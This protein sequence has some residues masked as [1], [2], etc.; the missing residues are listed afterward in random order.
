MHEPQPSSGLDFFQEQQPTHVILGDRDAVTT[1][2]HQ[3]LNLPYG[4]ASDVITSRVS[5]AISLVSDTWVFQTKK[6]GSDEQQAKKWGLRVMSELQISNDDGTVKKELKRQLKAWVV[7]SPQEQL[8][9]RLATAY[10][11][12]PDLFS[13]ATFSPQEAER[14]TA[15]VRTA[16]FMDNFG[17][18]E[19]SQKETLA[20]GVLQQFS[21]YTI[22]YIGKA[23]KEIVSLP[24]LEAAYAMELGLYSDLYD[25]TG[26]ISQLANPLRDLKL[27]IDQ[28]HEREQML[29]LAAALRKELPQKVQNIINPETPESS[30]Q[31]VPITVTLQQW[32]A[33]LKMLE[34]TGV[35]RIAAWASENNRVGR[36]TATEISAVDSADWL[37]TLLRVSATQSHFKGVITNIN[38]SKFANAANGINELISRIENIPVLA[39]VKP[40]VERVGQWTNRVLKA[41]YE[42]RDYIEHGLGDVAVIERSIAGITHE[43]GDT[44][45]QEL[46]QNV[47]VTKQQRTKIMQD[48]DPAVPFNKLWE[49][50]TVLGSRYGQDKVFKKLWTQ[51]LTDELF[52][53]NSDINID[54]IVAELGPLAE[55]KYEKKEVLFNHLVR[56][57]VSQLVSTGITAVDR[58]D[59]HGVV[60]VFE[61]LQN[62][63]VNPRYEEVGTD[64]PFFK[65]TTL[66]LVEK[67]LK[68]EVFSENVGQSKRLELIR[69]WQVCPDTGR[70][71][72]RTWF[73]EHDYPEAAFDDFVFARLPQWLP[74]EEN[75][76]MTIAVELKPH[77]MTLNDLDELVNAYR[78]ASAIGVESESY[79]FTV[80]YMQKVLSEKAAL[81]LHQ[82][83]ER[84]L[85]KKDYEGIITVWQR[86]N[87]LVTHEVLAPK[88]AYA[89]AYQ[90]I[91]EQT[92]QLIPQIANGEDVKDQMRALLSEKINGVPVVRLSQVRELENFVTFTHDVS[93]CVAQI[94]SVRSYLS[95][96]GTEGISVDR[97]VEAY[98]NLQ[99]Q[100]MDLDGRA[101]QMTVWAQE[102]GVVLSRVNDAREAAI[103]G[104]L[105]TIEGEKLVFVSAHKAAET[106][107][108]P[109]VSAARERVSELQAKMT[110]A[111]KSEAQLT[112]E[113]AA[114]TERL[115]A[116]NHQNQELDTALVRGDTLAAEKQKQEAQQTDK[117]R[118]LAADI[119]FNKQ[120]IERLT[121][122]LASLEPEHL[123]L[124]GEHERYTQE[125]HTFQT[126][127]DVLSSLEE[128]VGSQA[129]EKHDLEEQ[130]ARSKNLIAILQSQQAELLAAKQGLRDVVVTDRQ[131]IRDVLN[132]NDDTVLDTVWA[133]EG[134]IRSVLGQFRDSA[135]FDKNKNL[136]DSQFAEI[137]KLRQNMSPATWYR[138]LRKILDLFGFSYDQLQ[139]FMTFLVNPPEVFKLSPNLK[140][141][142]FALYGTRYGE[143]LKT[144]IQKF[145]EMQ[146]VA[147]NI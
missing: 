101:A 121:T 112:G 15:I 6:V 32:G 111:L 90:N 27:D 86:A 144:E 60:M 44:N 40:V 110:V 63:A 14:V 58:Q 124:F 80:K 128:S 107:I 115:A 65:S 33:V 53:P 133:L 102:L 13:L 119:A 76:L 146:E 129:K 131:E 39:P 142:Q 139:E 26:R 10:C 68:S 22:S 114:K 147:K 36:N 105:A 19:A 46:Q 38:I 45:L 54:L 94:D 28:L 34:V 49:Q 21:D 103:R 137:N 72:I 37:G 75:K 20:K 17:T 61:G 134:A 51:R 87:S 78:T 59:L 81:I 25:A 77:F 2:V 29:A 83:V 93:R 120:E 127:A 1:Q 43:F 56:S 55:R 31:P 82:A 64:A 136:Y 143:V 71:V 62:L 123:R 85:S 16:D 104:G 23:K 89:T 100:V 50:R 73:R 95:A 84:Y 109:V 145:Q 5:S 138:A 74:L 141:L 97:F 92:R 69:V 98:Q 41:R 99:V 11:F 4:T 24:A 126:E 57:R 12:G 140:L 66:Q 47:K 8:E 79:F 35:D 70:E 30:S 67:L 130:I 113:L 108:S 91:L 125:L 106:L 48:L 118:T 52:N 18:A 116:L 122:Q 3:F 9:D 88:Y 7:D 42:V 132:M 135:T 96:A 117:L